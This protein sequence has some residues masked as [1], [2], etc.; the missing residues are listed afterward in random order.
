MTENN[1][2]VRPEPYTGE[3]PE[4]YEIRNVEVHNLKTNEI[5]WIPQLV[6][7]PP[8]SEEEQIED[9]I[10]ELKMKL[11]KKTIT[12]DEKEELKLLQA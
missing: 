11:I 1:E 5:R 8:K 7:L 3:V 6:E 2:I 12:E 10:K 9:R 4:G